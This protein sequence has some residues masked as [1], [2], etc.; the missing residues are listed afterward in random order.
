MR[1]NIYLLVA[2]TITA[3]KNESERPTIEEVIEALAEA[4]QDNDPNFDRVQF[5]NDCELAVAQ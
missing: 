1:S 2:D 5:L 4:F 3:V